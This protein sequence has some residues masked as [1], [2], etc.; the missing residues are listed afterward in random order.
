MFDWFWEF[1]YGLVKAALYCIDFI[2]DIA[3]MLCGIEPV[4][5]E[6]SG[7]VDI[8]G[9]FLMHESVVNAFRAVVLIGFALLVVFTIYSIIRAQGTLGEGKSPVRICLDSA[10]ILLYFLLVPLIM[11][12]ASG[13]ISYVMNLIY[14]AT[15]MGGSASVGS[16]MFCIFADEAYSSSQPKGEIMEAFLTGSKDY[17]S[18]GQVTDYFDLEDFNYFLGF[19]GGVSVLVLLALSLLSFVERLLSL[20]ILFIVAPL[21]MST[22]ALDDG[23]R[24]KLWRDQTINKFLMAYGS[25]ICINL[26]MMMIG[27]VNEINFFDP[28]QTFFNGLARLAFIIGGAFACRK[29]GVLI[30]NL[31]NMGA[32]TQSAMDQS[33][34]NRGFGGLAGLVAGKALAVA[35]FIAKPVAKASVA[36]VSSAKNHIKKDVLASVHRKTNA[37]R[38]AKD[39]ASRQKYLARLTAQNPTPAQGGTGQSAQPVGTPD[40]AQALRGGDAPAAQPTSGNGGSVGQTESPSGLNQTAGQITRD[41]LAGINEKDSDGGSG[42]EGGKS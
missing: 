26:Y 18:T 5:V 27:I 35:G 28:D 34:L 24:F 2:A 25:L 22:A 41:A 12:L 3:E 33:N 40:I 42:S 29:G 39:E 4:V 14:K 13:C 11:Y 1:L 37:K 8:T 30:G 36:P 16:S 15:S 19:I 17:Y 6:G 7:E 9:Y 20:M 10:K 23:A 38:A 32:G 31:I 21:S